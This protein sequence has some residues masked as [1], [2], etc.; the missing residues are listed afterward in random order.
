MAGLGSLKSKRINLRASAA[1]EQLLRGV[2]RRKGKTMT[3]FIVESACEAAERETAD[4]KEFRVS[5]EKWEA[6]LAALERP[7]RVHPRLRR[8]FAKPTVLE[9]GTQLRKPER[10]EKDHRKHEARSSANS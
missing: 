7:A 5:P 3:E 2:A 8:L 9:S 10:R 4:E 6:F 1:Q